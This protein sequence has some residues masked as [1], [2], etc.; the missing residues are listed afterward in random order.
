MRAFCWFLAM[1]IAGLVGIALFS[2]PAW[3]L[4]HPHFAVPFHRVGERIGML[5]LLIVF[6]LSARDLGVSDRGSLGYGIPKCA[7]VQ[8]TLMGLLLG[9]ITMSGGVA[10]MSALGLLDWTPADQLRPVTVAQVIVLRLLSGLAVALIEETFIRGAM[11]TAIARE[12]GPRAAVLL[13][14]VLYSASHFFA[15]FHIAPAQVSMA[16]G[17][18]LLG[19]TLHLFADP[20]YI[21]DA[22]ACLFAVGVVLAIVRLT[23]G[24]IAACLGLHAG[25]VWVMLVVHEMAHPRR[26]APFSYLLSRFDGFVGWLVLVWTVLLGFGLHALYTRRVRNL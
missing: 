7:F 6:L 18:A 24:N 16:S 12:S 9:V 1:I 20:L 15:S 10:L 17:V 26:E 4:L 8:E 19:G 13:T 3:I 14:S 11:L 5:T 25:W 21:L 2:Y 23:T 22:F